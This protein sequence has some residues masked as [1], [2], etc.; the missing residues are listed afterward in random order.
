MPVKTVAGGRPV[1]YLALLAALIAGLLLVAGVLDAAFAQAGPFGAPRAQPPP[2]PAAGVLGWIFAK[3]AEF[4]RQ[5]SS[6][7]RAAKADGTAAWSLFGLSFLYGVFHAAGPGH[8]KAVISSYMVANEETW[9]RGV[10]LSF[11]SAGLQALVAVAVVG[12]A[13]ALL[14]ATAATMN[15]AVNVIEIVS[16][17]LIILVGLRLLWVKGRAFI[18]TMRTLNRPAPVGAA[19]TPAPD[20]HSHDHHAHDHQHDHGPGCSHH[21]HHHH[22]P[23]NGHAHHHGHDGH[24]HD[25]DDHASAW[26]HAHAPE[27]EE[28]AG[29]GGWKRGLSAIVAVG[30]R[31]C[32]GA[33]LVLVFALAQGLFWAGVVATFVMG[34]G[35]AI[36]VAAIATLAVAAKSWAKRFADARSGYGM[37][38]MRGVEVAAAIVI[39][40][41]GGLLL[42]GYMVSERMV[43]M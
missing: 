19:V 4:Y 12:I 20:H 11:A 35:T 42:T 29:P 36:T 23:G 34:L 38:A 30:L 5:F 26:G 37:L 3:Q 43:G 15:R 28:L 8:G 10:V 1:V 25:Q 9:T 2:P 27:P 39:V 7:I 40:A 16:Y 41:F 21:A 13:A 6:L 32:S 24:A 33:I 18:S 31:P 22:Q 17:S 14:N